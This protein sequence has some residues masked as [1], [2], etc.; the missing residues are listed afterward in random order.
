MIGGKSLFEGKVRA[1]GAI[2]V[3]RHISQLARIQYG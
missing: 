2:L 1:P 3:P